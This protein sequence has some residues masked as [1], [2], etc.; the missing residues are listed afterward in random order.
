MFIGFSLQ[1]CTK[2]ID[3]NACSVLNIYQSGV[4][5]GYK[6]NIFGNL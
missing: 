3:F 4:H 6:N 2:Y 5:Y 1:L